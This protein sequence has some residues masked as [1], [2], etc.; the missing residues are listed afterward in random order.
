MWSTQNSKFWP[1][2]FH[3]FL[4][5]SVEGLHAIVVTDRDGVPVVKGMRCHVLNENVSQLKWWSDFFLFV[6]FSQVNTWLSFPLLVLT[7][8]VLCPCSCEW[9]CP[10]TCFKTWLLVHLCSGNRSR[11]QAGPV[12]KQEHHLLLQWLPGHALLTSLIITEWLFCPGVKPLGNLTFSKMKNNIRQLRVLYNPL[13]A[14]F[15]VH[16]KSYHQ[17]KLSCI[18]ISS[19]V[20]QTPHFWLCWDKSLYLMF[21]NSPI[22][23]HCFYFGQIV[24]FNRLPLVISF[25]A[26][27]SANTGNYQLPMTSQHMI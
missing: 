12:Q 9:Q 20:K 16:C 24:Q 4:V 19:V 25:I 6:C 3:L 14:T 10:S 21:L 2:Y 26:G 11:Q 23:L 8:F 22:N 15:Q 27:S 1:D 7:N 13:V 17:R 5:F 18:Q